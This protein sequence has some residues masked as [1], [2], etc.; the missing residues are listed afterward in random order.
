MDIFKKLAPKKPKSR[1]QEHD[2]V[3]RAVREE[4]R[5][6]PPRP[7]YLESRAPV[8]EDL[9]L[10]GCEVRILEDLK[11]DL[12]RWK[13]AIPVLIAWLDRIE[14]DGPEDLKE[15]IARLLAV[16]FAKGAVP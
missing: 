12:T 13:T 5:N 1:R 10:A 11:W 6:S 3:V 8:L 2:K 15:E 9:K 14:G 16:P 4:L 7:E